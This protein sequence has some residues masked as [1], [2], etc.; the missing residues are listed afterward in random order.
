VA[1]WG[2]GVTTHPNRIACLGGKYFFDDDQQF[3]DT[4]YSVCEYAAEG[5]PAGRKKQLI[6]EQRDW[7]PYTQ[8]GYENGIAFYGK[9][10]IVVMGHTVGWK[11]YGPRDKLIAEGSGQADLVA[12]HTNFLDCVRGTQSQLNADVHAGCLSATIVHLSNIAARTGAVLHFDPQA[13]R[14]TNQNRRRLVGGSTA[15]GTG[16]PKE[17]A[18]VCRL[19]GSRRRPLRCGS[20]RHDTAIRLEGLQLQN[21]KCKVG[22][23]AETWAQPPRP[24][25]GG[26]DGDRPR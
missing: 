6:F 18:G 12:H 10:G 14:I 25:A 20:I 22:L 16:V 5:A 17:A 3:P 15:A 19:A 4:Q 1:C 2:L 8:D 23:I 26:F 7:S 24:E 13:E 11:L 21:D 9:E